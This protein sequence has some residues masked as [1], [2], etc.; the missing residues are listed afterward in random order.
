MLVHWDAENEKI[1][2]IYYNGTSNRNENAWYVG[3]DFVMKATTNLSALKSHIEISNALEKSGLIAATPIATKEGKNY[4]LDDDVY[5]SLT[6]RLHGDCI[7]SGE[8]YDG[9]YTSKS[10][11]LGEILGQLH[12]I[13]EKYDKDI[14]CNNSNLLETVSSWALPKTKEAMALPE[15]FYSDYLDTFGTLFVKLPKQ[16]IH[17]DPNP[18]NIILEDGKLSGF[19]DFDLTERNVRLFDPCYASTA[20][21]S[22]GFA[23]GD[24]EK[25]DK[26]IEIYK[27]IIFGYDSVCKLSKEENRALPYVIFS[28]QMICVAYF[29]ET[30]KYSELAQTNKKMLVWLY[31]NRGKLIIH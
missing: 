7:K 22:E 12:L 8:M 5:F 30:D 2:D 25:L 31:E 18:G 20:I 17:R 16:I 1:T 19:I 28:I 6:K 9:D 3:S 11:Y 4:I 10:R 23:Q 13:L 27:N 26:W 14:I 15:A 29:N 24:A 21:L